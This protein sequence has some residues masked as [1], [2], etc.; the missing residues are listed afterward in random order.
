MSLR[1]LSTPF[2]ENKWM[3][4]YEMIAVPLSG[5]SFPHRMVSCVYEMHNGHTFQGQMQEP[6]MPLVVL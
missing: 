5:L 6:E 2:K 3:E 4:I 1:R